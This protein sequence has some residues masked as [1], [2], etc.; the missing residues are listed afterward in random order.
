MRYFSLMILLLG[1]LSCDKVGDSSR[2]LRTN[3]LEGII[4]EFE[5]ELRTD[6]I[7][8][9]ID[10]SIS[11]AIVH[12]N[13]VIWSKAFGYAD[14]KN[15][16]LAD[17]TTIYRA[18]SISKSF[19]AFLMMKLVEQGT[20]KLT[21]P[22]ELYF[23]EIKRL[24]GYSDSTRITLLQLASHTSGLSREPQLEN[25][26][27]GRIND[28]EKK[29][30]ASIPTCYFISKPGTKYEYSNIGFSILGLTL[31][32][33]AKKPFMQLMVD[34]VFIPLK[35]SRSLYTVSEELRPKLALGMDGGPNEII[36]T[37]LPEA[38]H[39]GRGYKVPTGGIY[40]TPN[41]LAKFMICNL[42]YSPIIREESRE[43]MQTEKGP[44]PNKY[45]LGFM[46]FHYDQ[47]YVVGHNGQMPGYTSQFAFEKESKY[48]V[49]LMRNYT[50]GSTDLVKA[51]F[52]LLS[53][54]RKLAKPSR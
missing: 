19:T 18:A 51:S 16:V 9:S 12:G 24:P 21:D 15:R 23:P 25:A 28:W 39:Y 43:L 33:A 4:S 48:G 22:V 17:T 29:L 41:D 52:I 44:L 37:E 36:D 3:D 47:I 11:V 20:I 54:L 46:L 26:D 7:K 10:G 13:K 2:E 1:F 31:S 34:E 35:M 27:S 53:K 8:D 40:T 5:S 6:L 38:E 14:R 50:R 32:R 49:I 30:I 45:G 42:G